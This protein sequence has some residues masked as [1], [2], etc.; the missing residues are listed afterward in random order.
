MALNAPERYWRWCSF[1][2]AAE[3]VDYFNDDG[4]PEYHRLEQIRKRFTDGIR[5]HGDI[6]DH[7]S[8]DFHLV[9]PNDML[10]K[11]DL[12]SMANSLEVR[13]PLLDHRIAEF[14]FRL[15]E[16]Y[17]IK[18]RLKKRILQDTFRHILPQELYNRPKRG[19]E[20][21]LLPWFRNELR[22]LITDDLLSD[23]FIADQGIFDPSYIQKLKKRLFS[24]DPGDI[25]AQIWGLI[26]FQSWYKHH[27]LA[28]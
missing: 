18:E 8:A 23:R 3:S 10:T 14:A 21:P 28:S 9:L 17:K 13:V 2:S 25:H 22:S 26:V 11:V 6:N 1:I 5:A 15:P 4:Q 19:F 12:M 16:D 7:L 24:R 27:H 20:V